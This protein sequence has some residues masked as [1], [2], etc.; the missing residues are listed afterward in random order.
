MSNKHKAIPLSHQHYKDRGGALVLQARS[1]K[2]PTLPSK[3]NKVKHDRA[4]PPNKA[5]TIKLKSHQRALSSI[6]P[7]I[8]AANAII[9]AKANDTKFTNLTTVVPKLT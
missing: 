7:P 9:T 6:W 5:E 3:I 1:Q 8:K 2:L 4:K